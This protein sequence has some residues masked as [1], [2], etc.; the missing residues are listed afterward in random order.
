M[1]ERAAI[2]RRP[3]FDKMNQI[4]EL[5]MVR[6][7]FRQ[8]QAALAEKRRRRPR[9]LLGNPLLASKCLPSAQKRAHRSHTSAMETKSYWRFE[10]GVLLMEGSHSQCSDVAPTVLSTR[11]T[12]PTPMRI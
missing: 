4:S 2:K 8:L 11:T 10:G 5:E 12:V 7:F 9:L 6:A 1:E 3:S